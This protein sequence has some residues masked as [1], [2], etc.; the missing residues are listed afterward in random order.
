[1]VMGLDYTQEIIGVRCL[2]LAKQSKSKVGFG[3][4]LLDS[5]GNILG[6]GRNRRSRSGEFQVLGG[7]VDYATHAE[8]AAVIDALQ[9]GFGVT[10][11]A[12]YVL[13]V[14][15]KGKDGRLVSVR[16]SDKSVYFSC[17]RCARMFNKFGVYVCIPLPSGWHRLSPQD[18]LTTAQQLKKECRKLSFVKLAI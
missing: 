11:C 13:G 14:R 10:G 9:N 16:P 7:G 15:L 17:I 1:M 4:V 2:Q 6:E 12:I 18:A 3:A 5:N 8:Q